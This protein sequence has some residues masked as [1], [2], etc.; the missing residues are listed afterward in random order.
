MRK[1][2]SLKSMLLLQMALPIVFLLT[3]LQASGK[4]ESVVVID[5][6]TTFNQEIEVALNGKKLF[7]SKLP[8]KWMGSWIDSIERTDSGLKHGTNELVVHY[9]GVV[10]GK[11]ISPWAGPK[12]FKVE[13]KHQADKR[14]PE[15]SKPI[16]ICDGPSEVKAGCTGI[17]KVSFKLP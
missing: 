5:Y 15:T 14:R 6:Q 13:V 17:K 3:T 2:L 1:C 9:R 10:R 11:G 12:T 8:R 16:A 7:E 4:D